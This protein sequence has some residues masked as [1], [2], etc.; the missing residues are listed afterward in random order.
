MGDPKILTGAI[1]S[2]FFPF[3]GDFLIGT[4]AM[5]II[6]ASIIV[7][8]IGLLI[9]MA[10]TGSN[11]DQNKYTTAQSVS[12]VSFSFAYLGLWIAGMVLAWKAY[13]AS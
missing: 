8:L 12:L 3:V 13:S 10:W 11:V 9:I 6:G 2:I 5:N 1:L 4:T 7:A